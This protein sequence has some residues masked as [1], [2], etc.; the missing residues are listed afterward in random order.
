[1]KRFTRNVGLTVVALL[2][3]AIAVFGFDENFSVKEYHD[4]H[5]VLHHLQ[6]EA[7][8][9]NDMATIR[10]RAKELIGLGNKVVKLGVPKGTK[11]EHVEKFKTGLADFKNKLARYGTDAKSGSDGDLKTSYEAVHDSFEELADMLPAKP[12]H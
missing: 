6:H 3:I 4:F 5:E 11:A 7:L 1:M 2:S 10:S 9:K 8:P 12:K